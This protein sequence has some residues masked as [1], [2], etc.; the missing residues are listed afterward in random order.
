MHCMVHA[1]RMQA[2][3]M[4]SQQKANMEEGVL[5]AY[6]VVGVRGSPG[7]ALQQQLQ[8]VH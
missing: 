1:S 8:E 7:W 2:W 3:G 4:T 6:L 5:H